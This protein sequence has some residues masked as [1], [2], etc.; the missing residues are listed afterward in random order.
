MILE[1]ECCL[2]NSIFESLKA[3][4]IKF[5]IIILFAANI[6]SSV[7][8]QISFPFG[9]TL[10]LITNTNSLYLETRII[11]H[12]GSFKADD[13][14]WEKV[15]D[16]IDTNWS[17]SACFNGDCKN[18][19]IQSG[20]F[21]RDFGLNDTTCFIAFHVETLNFSGTSYI[22]Y[23]VFNKHNSSDSAYLIYHITFISPTGID[24]IAP[25]QFTCYPSLATNSITILSSV[26]LKD[27]QY[28]IWNL[29]GITQMHSVFN[30]QN[31]HSEIDITNLAQGI[32]FLQILSN[33]QQHTLKF[34]KE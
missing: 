6:C 16:S 1:L 25:I 2:K 15:S 30:T 21:I 26:D 14:L 23:K 4:I 22:K 9:N 13:Y 31:L 24:K 3:L 10:N 32:Y 7:K 29:N 17:V 34:I 20:N 12:T 33:N 8:A 11:F 5:G 19:L 18:D 28:T 27:A